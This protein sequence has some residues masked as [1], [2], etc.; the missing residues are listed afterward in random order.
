MKKRLIRLGAALALTAAL[1]MAQ[2]V[3]SQKEA[4]DHFRDTILGGR[5]P[6]SDRG[7]IIQRRKGR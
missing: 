5:E 6:G 1:G 4:E 2:K 3:K 7:S